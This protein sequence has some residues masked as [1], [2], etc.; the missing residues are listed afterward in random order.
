MRPSG[1]SVPARRRSPLFT[2]TAA[3]I[4]WVHIYISLLGFTALIFFAATGITLNHPTWFGGDVQK[5]SEFQGEMSPRWLER[6]V[7]DSA[8]LSP[9][10]EV[11]ESLLID[12]LSVVE[13]L[14]NA[15]HIRG[16][17]AEF[18][19]DDQECMILFKGPAYAADVYVD[20]ISGKYSGTLTTMGAVALMNDLHKGRDSGPVWSWV[21]DLSALLMIVV[22]VTGLIL[23]LYL[24]RKRNSG[25]LTAVVGTVLFALLYFVWVP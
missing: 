24:K 1:A 10:E 6:K 23:V 12:R 16:A 25:I 3:T 15:H 9:S 22:S 5:I 14:R 20:R 21:I 18:R 7:P 2:W 13:H 17:V 11:D 19:A 4:R 8:S